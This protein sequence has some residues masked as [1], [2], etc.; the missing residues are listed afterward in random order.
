MNRLARFLQYAQKVF[1]LKTLLRRVY[2]PR[3]FDAITVEAGYVRGPFLRAVEKRGGQWV[4][5]FKQERMAAYHEALQLSQGQKPLLAFADP[6]R[7]KQVRLWEV[8]DLHF[9][10]SQGKPFRVV[11]SEEH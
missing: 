10:A 9:S 6:A 8:K 5:V 4:V 7:D 3:F 1:G 2:G 11:R